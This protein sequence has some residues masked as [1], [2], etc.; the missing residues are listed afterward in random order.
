[1]KGIAD[2]FRVPPASFAE[3]REIV[4]DLIKQVNMPAEEILREAC[5]PGYDQQVFKVGEQLIRMNPGGSLD[6]YAGSGCGT[7]YLEEE[8][9]IITHSGLNIVTGKTV[10]L[11]DLVCHS[12]NLNPGLA[13]L[14]ATFMLSSPVLIASLQALFVKNGMTPPVMQSRRVLNTS[15]GLSEVANLFGAEPKQMIETLLKAGVSITEKLLAGV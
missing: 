15:G 1:M 6:L 2:S 4:D 5:K 9:A 12:G 3:R 10:F 7:T 11:D 8:K 13:S 14:D